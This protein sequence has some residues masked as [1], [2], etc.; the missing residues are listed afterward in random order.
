MD[1]MEITRCKIEEERKIL[2]RM[3]ARLN[4]C[5]PGYLKCVHVHGKPQYY[6]VLPGQPRPIYINRKHAS[7]VHELKYK[8]ILKESVKRLRVN[9]LL[10]EKMIRGLKPWDYPTVNQQLP[11]TY[12][13]AEPDWESGAVKNG[14][15]FTQSENPAFRQYLNQTT[16]FGLITRTRAEAM[17]AEQLYSAGFTIYYEKK[18]LLRDEKG[19]YHRRYPDFTVPLAHGMVYYLEH[20]GMFQ[21]PKYRA[22]DEETMRLYHLNGIYEPK[23]LLVTMDGPDETFPAEDIARMIQCVLMPLM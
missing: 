23:N 9:L 11:Q 18:L 13:M 19:N 8:R 10:E 3:E 6:H 20:K 4:Q 15:R 16:T 5:P 22:R 12:Q 17:Y 2:Q 1:Y 14:L 21:D 7:L